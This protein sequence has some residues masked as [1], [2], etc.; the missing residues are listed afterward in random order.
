MELGPHGGFIMAAYAAG[1]LVILVLVMWVLADYRTQQR[2]LADL[3]RQ[4]ATRR[5]AR[6][7]R[8]VA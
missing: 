7:P 2:L 1:V 4:G 8:E 3:E 6:R 5:S